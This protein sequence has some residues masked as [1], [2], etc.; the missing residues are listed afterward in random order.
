MNIRPDPTF[1]ASPRLA[2]EAPPESFAY[3]VLLSPGVRWAYNFK[4]GM[5]IVPGVA[6]PIGVGPSSGDWGIL[7]YFS[8]EHPYRKLKAK[9]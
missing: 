9:K 2:M 6:C 4:S 7:L 5:Q 8:I 1:Y 3:T